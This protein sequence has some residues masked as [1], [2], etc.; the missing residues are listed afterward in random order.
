M[1][2][3]PFTVAIKHTLEKTF[4]TVATFEDLRVVFFSDRVRKLLAYL[5][6]ISPLWIFREDKAN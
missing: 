5:I 2:E 6:C 3:K 4:F 1:E